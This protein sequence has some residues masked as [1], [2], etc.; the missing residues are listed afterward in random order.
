MLK[1]V[2][3][4][5]PLRDYIVFES[6]PAFSCNTYPVFLQLR[7]DFPDYKLIWSIDR[8]TRH[9]VRSVSFYA[10]EVKRKRQGASMRWVG[11]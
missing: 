2:L 9:T 5:F 7:K 8:N 4:Y 6:N 3:W 1:S 10:M 11:K